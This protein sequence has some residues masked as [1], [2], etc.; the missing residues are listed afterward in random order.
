M[1]RASVFS[2]ILL[3]AASVA[4]DASAAEP[5]NRLQSVISAQYQEAAD[6]VVETAEPTDPAQ[7]QGQEQQ[8]HSESPANVTVTQDSPSNV[9]VSI[10]IFSPGDDGDVVQTNDAGAAAG[11]GQSTDAVQTAAPAPQ[12]APASPDDSE[13]TH[14]DRPTA[15]SRPDPAELVETAPTTQKP[16]ASPEPE[17][18]SGGDEVSMPDVSMPDVSLPGSSSPAASLPGISSPAAADS[19]GGSQSDDGIPEN[20][21]W[22]W[23]SACFGGG[24]SAAPS[25]PVTGQS[26]WQWL[27]SC[28]GEDNDRAAPNLTAGEIAAIAEDP[29]DDGTLDRWVA[30]QLDDRALDRWMAEQL[31][32]PP[33]ALAPPAERAAAETGHRRHPAHTL[34]AA[35]LGDAPGG[36]SSALALL[37]GQSGPPGPPAVAAAG[38]SSYVAAERAAQPVARARA[39]EPGGNPSSPSPLGAGGGLA[40]SAAGGL[41]TASSLLLGLW[42]AVLA[43]ALVMVIPR[44]RRRRWSGPTRRPPQPHAARL[45]RPG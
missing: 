22:Q 1:S 32:S 42:L 19:A 21:V 3:A 15:P 17:N 16:S 7:Y 45:E 13:P 14:V 25:P 18:L 31:G 5:E 40:A 43:S 24:P 4:A 38:S 27:W 44:L 28:A 39:G 9:N 35:G 33:A 12:T 30:G 2:A 37:P 11:A 23:T 6:P 8:Y 29:L 41:G 10:R 20:W 26:G 36:S 34:L